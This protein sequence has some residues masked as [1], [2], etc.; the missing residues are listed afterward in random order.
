MRMRPVFSLKWFIILTS[1]V[2][3]V[4]GI[5][6]S[7]W[8]GGYRE[9]QLRRYWLNRG[10]NAHLEEGEVR[11]LHFYPGR[12]RDVDLAEVA[13]LRGLIDLGVAKS[14]ITDRG[15]NYLRG[16]KSLNCLYLDGTQV[17]DECLKALRTMPNLAFVTVARTA[18]SPKGARELR[19]SSRGRIGIVGA[20]QK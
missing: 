15:V 19:R 20:G 14:A 1:V 9:E 5:V 4:A 6:G 2:G 10:A 18:V 7:W 13:Q 3:V 17:T 16:H 11:G 8:V 12:C